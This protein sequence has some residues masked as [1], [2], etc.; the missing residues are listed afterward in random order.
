VT[1]C[2]QREGGLVA[3]IVTTTEAGEAAREPCRG[4][5]VATDRYVLDAYRAE[6]QPSPE[7]PVRAIMDY[8]EERFVKGGEEVKE[9]ISVSF[10][11]LLPSKGEPGSGLRD[12]LG[13]ELS[14]EAKRVA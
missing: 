1:K 4:A 6:T 7:A 8:L 11:E 9:L 13:L 3:V 12:L 2:K 14:S 10:L 5:A